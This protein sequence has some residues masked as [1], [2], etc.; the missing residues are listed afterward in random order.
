[1]TA[2]VIISRV[3]KSY[4]RVLKVVRRE[5]A[6]A[7]LL[8]EQLIAAAFFMMAQNLGSL[9]CKP[10]NQQRTYRSMKRDGVETSASDYNKRF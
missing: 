3:I 5:R 7:A 10:V 2:A 9:N 8:S 6:A 4:L 1:M